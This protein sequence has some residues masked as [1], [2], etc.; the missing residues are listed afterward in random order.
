MVRQ[1]IKNDVP[2]LWRKRARAGLCPVC[3]KTKA[4]FDKGMIVY[5]SKKCR[6]AY[7]SHYEIWSDLR[8]KILKRDKETCKKCG[9]N[10]EKAKEKWEKSKGKI[11]REF[12]VKEAKEIEVFR[13]KELKLLSE[14]YEE[15][16]KEI[17][18]DLKLFRRINWDLRKQFEKDYPEIFSYF[19][20]TPSFH[21]DHIKAIINDGDMWDENNLQV[22]CE[23]CHKKKTKEDMLERKRRKIKTKKLQGGSQ[24]LL[25][26]KGRVS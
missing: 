8:D 13:N 15:E 25:T 20:K 14:R 4:E 16:Y 12:F 5:C 9:I 2:E 3:G 24:F 23:D 22:L 21:V 19:P 26:L 7:A 1:L 18:N 17:M 11:L 10:K 6:D